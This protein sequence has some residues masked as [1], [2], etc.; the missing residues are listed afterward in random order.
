MMQISSNVTSI[1][2]YTFIMLTVI[3]ICNESLIV[4]IFAKNIVQSKL[5]KS[6]FRDALVNWPLIESKW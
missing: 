6:N 2:V 4:S 1:N 5:L 3:L